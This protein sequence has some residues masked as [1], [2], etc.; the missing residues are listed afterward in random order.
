PGRRRLLP[1]GIVLDDGSQVVRPPGISRKTVQ[2]RRKLIKHH[3]SA[4]M[5]PFVAGSK[6]ELRWHTII[7][8]AR[9][10]HCSNK[11]VK[12]AGQL[13]GEIIHFNGNTHFQPSPYPFKMPLM[14]NLNAWVIKHLLVE[15]SWGWRGLFGT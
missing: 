15:M 6:P 13:A 9:L 7:K 2:Q 10:L 5:S 12:S 3:G 1:Q 4:R 14:I 11:P 8:H